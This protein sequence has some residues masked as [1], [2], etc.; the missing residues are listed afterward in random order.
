VR[1]T[2]EANPNIALIK[3]WGKADAALNLPVT[4][5]LSLTLDA[6]PTR[7]TVTL[8]AGLDRD[9]FLLAGVEQRGRPLE[10][11]SAFLDLV[12]TA[13]GR[14]ERC[15]V[16]STNLIP[17]GAGLASS[18]S[19]FAAL[20]ASSA[21]AFG[22]DLDD[23]ALSRLARRGSGSASRSVFGGFVRWHAGDDAASFAEP[24]DSHGLELAMVVAI[25]VDAPKAVSSTEAMN[26]T[27]ATSPFYPAWADSTPR[28]LERMLSAIERA[29]FTAVGELAESNSLRMHATMA[30][31]WPPVRYATGSSV[32]LLDG[33]RDLRAAGIEGY[34]TM[35]A[36]PNVK[37]LCQPADAEAV[38]TRLAGIAPGARFLSARSGEGVRLLPEG[39]R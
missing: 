24:V 11:V 20:A 19:G 4:G 39:T 3:Y 26:R 37:V 25:V 14:A 9:V 7:T 5:S 31:A 33:V 32:A 28:Q 36:G 34:A 15:T 8:D 12:R 38:E 18:A 1:A 22:L 2:A 30:G 27:T 21:R 10:R 23:R 29:D 35:D 16:E 17:T 6:A 13:S